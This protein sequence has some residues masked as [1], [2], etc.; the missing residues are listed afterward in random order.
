MIKEGHFGFT[1][2]LSLTVIAIITKIFYISP[3][4]IINTLGTAA[5]QGTLISCVTCLIFFVLLY[6]LMKR[7][8]QLDLYQIFEAVAGKI[9]G[10]IL[11]LVF[12]IY[13]LYY[14]S[15]N[16]R[17]FITILKTY[18]MPLTPPSFLI[19]AFL[20]VVVAF[21]YVGLEGIA[22][23]S[24]VY[25][26]IILGGILLIILLAIP[27]YDLDYLYPIWGNGIFLTIKTG[28]A[29]VGAYD[30]VVFLAIIIRSIHGLDNFK[31]AGFL[32]IIVS[33]VVFGIVLA[34]TLAAFQYHVG[35]ES[36]SGMYHLSR[37]I[38]FS[39]F[40]QRVESIF[41]FI[42]VISSVI[43]ISFAFYLA[44]SSYCRVFDISNHRPLLLPFA[45][46]TF[47]L[48]FLSQNVAQ[49]TEIHVKFIRV[50][51]SAIMIGIPMI[52]LAMAVIRRKKGVK[53]GAQ[54][55]AEA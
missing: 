46:L 43:S 41:M 17:E 30:E 52:I 13:I 29:R 40:F 54:S 48:T 42:W 9:L 21:A 6:N 53:K 51:S 39:R 50:Y 25:F 27:S 38:Y 7:F 20:A 11:I 49:L 26:Y 32:S 55:K 3:R 44:L 33:G 37:V 12:S 19:I 36:L 24:C 4:V 5:W 15:V 28:I 18:S 1:E 34:A 2:A 22:R 47:A 10:K 8:P 31:K 45:I 16:I 23:V 14:S 35:S